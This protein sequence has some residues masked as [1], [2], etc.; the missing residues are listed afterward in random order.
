MF[1]KTNKQI[2]LN[3][4]LNKQWRLKPTNSRTI[5]RIVIDHT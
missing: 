3:T 5:V 1:K 4:V 2:I